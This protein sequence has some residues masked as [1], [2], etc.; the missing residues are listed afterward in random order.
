VI[1][2]N[3]DVAV[4]AMNALALHGVAVPRDVSFVGWDDN[5]IA[6]LSHVDLTSV[7]QDP[8]QL[9]AVAVDRV[10]A[11]SNARDVPDRE[12]VLDPE[13]RIRSSTTTARHS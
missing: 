1:A 10:L 2:Y 7:A 13:L 6:R 3:D 9:A 11:R 5:E 12:V 4:A 8:H